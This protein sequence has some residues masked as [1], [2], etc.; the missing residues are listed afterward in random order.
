V[1]E[2]DWRDFCSFGDS[3]FFFERISNARESSFKVAV[4]DDDDVD[5]SEDEDEDEDEDEETRKCALQRCA[6]RGSKF[7]RGVWANKGVSSVIIASG[8]V[9]ELIEDVAVSSLPSAKLASASSSAVGGCGGNGG[10]GV[11]DG[12]D[13][14]LVAGECAAVPSSDDVILGATLFFRRSC[15]FRIRRSF[16]LIFL[17]WRS[18]FSN[19]VDS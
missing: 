12:E 15:K 18:S 9:E 1:F 2:S 14:K 13:D 10:V 4:D 17:C 3:F 7:S 16:A 6:S 11:E 8:G 19:L 5:E